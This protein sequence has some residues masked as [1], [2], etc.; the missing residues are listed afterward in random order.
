MG[1][2]VQIVQDCAAPHTQADWWAETLEWEVE[3][4]NPEFI[5][6]MIDQ[7][8]AKNTDVEEHHGNL[9]WKSGAA[10]SDP[11]SYGSPRILFQKVPEP[12]TVKNRMHIDVH[13]GRGELD[14][15]RATLEARGA[16]YLHTA[17]QGPHV[18]ITMADLEGNEF[19]V[20]ER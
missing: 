16:T 7:G 18:W 19:C 13:V 1:Y 5:Q 4:S 12:K 20:T 14:H 9:V 8:H 6:S 17:S 15:A 3:P 11:T 10:I 2:T